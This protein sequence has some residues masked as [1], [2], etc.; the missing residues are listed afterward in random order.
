[1]PASGR[2]DTHHHVVPPGYAALLAD[3]GLTAGGQWV[4]EWS[5]DTDLALMDTAGIATSILSVSMPGVHFGDDAEARALARRFNE[6]TAE[7]VKDRPDR[8]GF[9]ATLTLPDLDGALAETA[10]ALDTLGADGVVLL[11]NAAGTWLGDSRFDPLFDELNRRRAVVFVHPTVIPGLAPLEGIP[12]YAADF[13]LDTT[14]AAINLARSGTMERCPDLKVLLSHAGG[15]L[16]YVASR[17]SLAASAKDDPIDG[18]T[19]L[20]RFIFDVALSSSPT[21]LPALLAFT[22]PGHVTFGSDW[23]YAPEVVVKTFTDAYERFDLED[24]VRFSIDRG[25]AETL[26]PRLAAEA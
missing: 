3:K 2:I 17:V 10:Y 14:R 24:D 22:R 21:A 26:F 1:M 9:F 20:Q 12:T 19:Q 4:P 25:A 11:A 15:F 18:F 16:P 5:V 23:P 6:L 8:F 7:V 13:L